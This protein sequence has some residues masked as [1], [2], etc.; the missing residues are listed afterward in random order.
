MR[1][2]HFR[3]SDASLSRVKDIPWKSVRQLRP[4]TSS[5]QSLIF[6]YAWSSSLFRS[7]RFTSS[8]RPFSSSVAIF[9]PCVLVTR[10]FPHCLTLNTLGALMSYHSFLRKGSPAFFLPPFF[11][12]LV[13]RLFLPTAIASELVYPA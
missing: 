2:C 13:S 3:I 7:A 10:V 6:L 8:T 12:P 4:W 1:E 9:V 11:P 5:I